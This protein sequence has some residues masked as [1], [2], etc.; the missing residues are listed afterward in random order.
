MHPFGIKVIKHE[1][2]PKIKLRQI[3]IRTDADAS[4]RCLINNDH[5]E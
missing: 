4:N 2:L 5:K 3:F 1:F